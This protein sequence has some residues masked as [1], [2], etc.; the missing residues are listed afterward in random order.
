MGET[1]HNTGKESMKLG[2]NEAVFTDFIVEMSHQYQ[3]DT[4]SVEWVKWMLR[5]ISSSR[6]HGAVINP[7]WLR[8]GPTTYAEDREP[9][10]FIK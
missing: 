7:K 10:M 6:E 4:L 9:H 2:E 5:Q 3:M 8:V 1:E